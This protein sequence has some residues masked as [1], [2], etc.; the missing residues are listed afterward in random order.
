MNYSPHVSGALV[1]G[2]VQGCMCP[3]HETAAPFLGE[4][5]VRHLPQ[6]DL[7]WIL[8]TA[9]YRLALH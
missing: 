6:Q 3:G 8:E 9:S 5:R 2:A 7:A 1:R 4:N